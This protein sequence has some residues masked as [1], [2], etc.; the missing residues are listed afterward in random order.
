MK[1]FSHINGKNKF[2]QIYPL[3]YKISFYIDINYYFDIIA[4]LIYISYVQS[5]NY[6]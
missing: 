1:L 6:F 2:I 3:I 5:L 4:P